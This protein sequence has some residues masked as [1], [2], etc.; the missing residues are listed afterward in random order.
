MFRPLVGLAM[1]I[2]RASPFHPHLGAS[3]AKL[4]HRLQPAGASLRQSRIEG[5]T[6]ELDLSEVIDASLYYSGTFEPQAELI[7]R[8]YLRPGDIA[9]DVGANV[10]Y[11]AL[12]MAKLVGP[13]GRVT[14]IEPTQAAYAKLQRNLALNSFSNLETLKVALSDRETGET[15]LAIESSYRLDG[16]PNSKAE[17]VQVTTLD[18]ILENF[19]TLNFLKID[20]DGFE[21][22]VFRGGSESIRRLRPVI[23]FE[24]MP[25]AMRRQGDSPT[26]L[27]QSLASLGYCIQ[28]DQFSTVTDFEEL[29]RKTE[30]TGCNLLAL[31]DTRSGRFAETPI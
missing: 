1:R 29:W 15:E 24:V 19:T 31:P 18:R 23:F 11:H 20:V 28:T 25:A 17:T 16:I 22:K 12:P 27:L 8:K 26:E 3:L 10:G 2:Y 13:E 6:F 9:V 7:I 14:A 30:T 4:L 21:G 5:I